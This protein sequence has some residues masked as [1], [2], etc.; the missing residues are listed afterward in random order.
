MELMVINQQKKIEWSPALEAVLRAVMQQA[1]ELF[2]LQ[3]DEVNVLLVDDVQIQELNRLYRGQDRPTDVLS[4]ALC[5]A[6][7]NEPVYDMPEEEKS[8]LGDIV[9]SLETAWRQSQ[10]YGHGLDRETGFLA[11]HGLLHLLGYDHQ[12]DEE[13]NAMRKAEETILNAAGLGR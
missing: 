2:E 5:E 1:A 8:L 9:I 4:F 12:D 6:G 3:A 11:V 7:E 13:R 10:E